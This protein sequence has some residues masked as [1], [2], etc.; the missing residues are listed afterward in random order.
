MRREE[1]RERRLTGMRTEN[2]IEET[3]RDEDRR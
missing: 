2:R 3:N 1:R